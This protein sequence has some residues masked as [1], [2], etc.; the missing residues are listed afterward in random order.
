MPFTG[1]KKYFL[2]NIVTFMRDQIKNV[3][4]YILLLLGQYND[5]LTSLFKMCFVILTW[6]ICLTKRLFKRD[7]LYHGCDWPVKRFFTH[8]F[9]S[10]L[11]W[12]IKNM[13]QK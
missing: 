8:D 7:W 12:P 6:D 4:C 11:N 13:F 3:L 10:G 5:L 9:G 1:I 2:K